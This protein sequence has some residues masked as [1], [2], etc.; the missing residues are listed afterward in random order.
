MLD[1][2]HH[3]VGNSQPDLLSGWNSSAT[4]NGDAFDY[5]YLMN[6]SKNLNTMSF[7]EWSPMGQ[8]WTTRRG[9]E[10]NLT[11]G[12]KGVGFFDML[13]AYK[14]TQWAEPKGGWGLSNISANELGNDGKLEIDDIDNAWR[15]DPATFLEYNIRDVQA[16]VG[17]D[18][19]A[20]VTQMFQNLRSLSGAQFGDCHN[21]IDMLDI[22]FLRYAGDY[23]F[24]L[25]TNEKPERS[26]YYGAKVFDSKM[27]RHRNVIYYDVSSLYP[28][29][30]YQTNM[31]PE[32]I[33]GTEDDL[34]A[35][36]YSKEDCCFSYIDTRPTHI[37]KE[38]NPKYTKLYYLKPSVKEGFVRSVI[39]DLLE[40][41]DSYDGTDLYS[42]IKRTV[43]AVYGCVGDSESYGKGFRLFDWRMAE[44]I[45]LQG[46]KIITEAGDWGT[47]YTDGYITN[48]DTDGVGITMGDDK[49]HA[50]VVAEALEVEE[51]MTNHL[52]QWC[53]DTMNIEQ[54]A[55]VMESE[56]LMDPL[57]IPS[58]GNGN[59]VKK[60][61]AYNKVWEQ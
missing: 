2:F 6:R 9:Y 18:K 41:K 46:R 23:G 13:Q 33:V 26:W 34:D 39:S 54:S 30:M 19:S 38:S 43:N 44:S 17:I 58:D 7:E 11:M 24:A 35:S 57:F 15:D 52:Q 1:D 60:K 42:A 28:N 29:I 50:E 37:K 48:G 40:M 10:Q 55:M 20:G 47:D 45:T 14:K 8:V 3:Y 5:P 22:M 25:P 61:Y 4:D 49:E 53:E 27:G 12:A 31:S 32:T 21:P 56:K 51:K 59:T 36:E 16:V